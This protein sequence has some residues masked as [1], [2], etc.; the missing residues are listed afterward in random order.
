MNG[1][2]CQRRFDRFPAI[3]GHDDGLLRTGRK[4]FLR[5]EADHRFARDRQQRLERSH[6]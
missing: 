2:L 4:Q 3:A 6:P 5:A 1:Q